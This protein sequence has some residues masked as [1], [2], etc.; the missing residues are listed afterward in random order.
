ML[1]NTNKIVFLLILVPSHLIH[2]YHISYNIK[3]KKQI[4]KNT[5]CDSTVIVCMW[6]NF[7]MFYYTFIKK[8]TEGYNFSVFRMCWLTN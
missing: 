7:C 1:E 5:V 2:Q 8:W 6:F 4:I 3:K